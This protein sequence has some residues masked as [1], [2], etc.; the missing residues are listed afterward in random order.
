MRGSTRKRGATWTAYWDGPA[1]P[2]TGR[3]RQRSRGGFTRQKDAE[4]FLT[5]TISK[6]NAGTYVERWL[7]DLAA[8]DAGPVP[9]GAV[10]DRLL[11]LWGLLDDG[12]RREAVESWLTETLKRNLYLAGDLRLR[13]E[14]LFADESVDA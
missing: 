10:Q 9:A 5:T 12:G 6:V 3:R 7:N 13:L 2:R 14:E 8:E 11:G 1:D 4:A